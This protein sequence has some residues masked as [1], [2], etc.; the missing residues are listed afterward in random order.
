MAIIGIYGCSVKV[1]NGEVIFTTQCWTLVSFAAPAEWVLSWCWVVF[2]GTVAYDNYHLDY[3]VGL[4]LSTP[5]TPNTKRKG[6]GLAFWRR[7]TNK[8]EDSR[9]KLDSWNERK[10]L[11]EAAEE[12][13]AVM[14]RQVV[15]GSKPDS[16]ARSIESDAGQQDQYARVMNED[17]EIGLLPPTMPRSVLG[18]NGY[19]QVG[20]SPPLDQA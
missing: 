19:H 12:A 16:M 7:W 17:V 3:T 11:R 1:E 18:S 15:S 14:D 13:E 6:N 8:E 20:N 4:L 2:L 5:A 9:E 10:G